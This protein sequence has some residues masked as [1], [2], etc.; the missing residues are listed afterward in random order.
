MIHLLILVI[1]ADILLFGALLTIVA[2][3]F[4]GAPRQE[5]AKARISRRLRS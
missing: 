1:A 4:I 3:G 5:T 2:S